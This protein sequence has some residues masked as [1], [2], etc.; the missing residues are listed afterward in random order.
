MITSR[1]P[2]VKIRWYFSKYLYVCGKTIRGRKGTGGEK[3]TE[4]LDDVQCEA[5]SVV[6]EKTKWIQHVI[7]HTFSLFIFQTVF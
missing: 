4:G 7:S 6:D 3:S 2:L 5:E 1:E